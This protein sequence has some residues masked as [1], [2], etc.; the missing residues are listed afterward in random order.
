MKDSVPFFVRPISTLV[1]NR[2]LSSYLFPNAKKHFTMLNDQLKTSGGSY[3]CGDTLT[4]A[5]IL[6]SF[7]L[8]AAKDRLN[9][10]GTWDTAD[11]TWPDQFPFV[12]KYLDL[13]QTEEGYKRSVKRIEAIDNGSKTDYALM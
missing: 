4:A 1:A 2:I 9:L 11:G 10:F 8:I 3:L 7:P 5:D 12:K 13:L 6:M